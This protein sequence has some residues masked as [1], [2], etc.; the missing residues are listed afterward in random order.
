M[1]KCTADR[2]KKADDFEAN[3]AVY[4]AK[5]NTGAPIRKHDE[6]RRARLK[7]QLHE[8]EGAKAKAETEVLHGEFDDTSNEDHEPLD[9]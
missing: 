1:K 5:K 8:S 7:A 4:T 2:N 9:L 6:S 3:E